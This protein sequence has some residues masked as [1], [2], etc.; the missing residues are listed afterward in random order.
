MTDPRGE[1]H[2]RQ[3]VW[4]TRSGA[5][6]FPALDEVPPG[7]RAEAVMSGVAPGSAVIINDE[8]VRLELLARGAREVRHLHTMRHALRDL[9]RVPAIPGLALRGWRSGDAER[10]APV[11]VAAYGPEHPDPTPPDLTTAAASLTD[12]VED[13]DNPLMSAASQVALLEGQAVGAALILRSQHIARWRG[14]W[15]MNMFRAPDPAV[16]GIGGAMLTRALDVLSADGEPH[17]GLAVT[18]TN[19]AR[20]VYEGLGFEYDSEAWVFL[21]GEADH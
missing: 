10:L 18:S 11:L 14:P 1:T 17:L 16:P 15:L 3:E 7:E 13:P 4:P 9:R 2:L 8:K 12:L 6:I 20:R 21:T 19:P 5:L